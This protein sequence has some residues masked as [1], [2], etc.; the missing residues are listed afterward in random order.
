MVRGIN[1]KMKGVKSGDSDGRIVGYIAALTDQ[2]SGIITSLD[3]E[4]NSLAQQ[5][6]AFFL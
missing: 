4:D 1:A 6:V 5:I 2:P 3:T